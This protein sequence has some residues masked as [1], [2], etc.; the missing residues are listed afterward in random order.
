M[1]LSGCGVSHYPASHAELA[2]KTCV[3]LLTYNLNCDNDPLVF[4]NNQTHHEFVQQTL[5]IHL[6]EEIQH[7]EL[8]DS[9]RRH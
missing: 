5:P 4:S 2:N 8:E 7:T 1:M 9:R 6:R 3:S